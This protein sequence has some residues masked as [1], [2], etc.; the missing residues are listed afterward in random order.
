MHHAISV[1]K[2]GQTMVAAWYSASYET[3]PDTVIHMSRYEKNRWSVPKTIVELSG[4]GLGNP[5][6]WQTPNKKEVWLLFVILSEEDW[7]SALIARKVSNNG[8]KTWSEM[9]I[10]FDREGLMIKGKP[11]KLSNGNYLIPIYDEKKWTPMVLISDS[12][13]DWRM[14]GDTTAIGVIQPNVVECD[15]GALLMLSRS[16]MGKVYISRSFN[17]GLSWISSSK[18]SIPNPNSG[19]D[20]VKVKN[21]NFFVLAYNHSEFLRNRIDIAISYD[22]TSWSEPLNVMNGNGE[23]SYPCILIDNNELHIFFTQNRTNF[24]DAHANLKEIVKELKINV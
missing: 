20:L 12:G 18:M 13:K 9:E 8:G 24:I 5:V 22:G 1:E 17:Q 4:F 23:Y 6:L 10:L 21:K 15:D 2:I 11:L 3:S 19:I 14:Y 7:R 16:K